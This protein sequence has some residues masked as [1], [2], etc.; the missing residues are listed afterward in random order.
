MKSTDDEDLT[1]SRLPC[2]IRSTP[3]EVPSDE[4]IPPDSGETDNAPSRPPSRTNHIRLAHLVSVVLAITLLSIACG[5]R[6][7][8][9]PDPGEVE[10]S[11]DLAR[12]IEMANP[13]VETRRIDFAQRRKQRAP[14]RGLDPGGVGRESGHGAVDRA[15]RHPA[16]RAASQGHRSGRTDRA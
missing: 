8:T 15:K 1:P 9:P 10:H 11:I 3:S 16:R 6:G 2:D 7:M 12:Q 14:A 4:A 13:L 5:G